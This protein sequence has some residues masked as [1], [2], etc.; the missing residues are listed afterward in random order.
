MRKNNK[1]HIVAI[2][3]MTF[4]ITLVSC[5]TPEERMLE[6]SLDFAGS[7]RAQLETVLDHY[8]G[9]REKLAAAKFLIRNM[10]RYYSYSGWAARHNKEQA[11]LSCQ[12]SQYYRHDH[13]C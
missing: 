5:S 12:N 7:N 8:A 11:C 13:C 4:F 1:I 9:D 2:L 10:P 6:Q 3:T